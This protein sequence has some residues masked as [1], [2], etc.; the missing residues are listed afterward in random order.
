M[1]RDELIDALAKC[2][3]D[4]VAVAQYLGKSVRTIYRYM[5]RHGITRRLT[6]VAP[7]ETVIGH[8]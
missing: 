3:D 1:T 8:I 5:K 2:G 7:G 4:P 6:V